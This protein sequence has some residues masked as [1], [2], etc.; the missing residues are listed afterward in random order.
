MRTKKPH[1][2]KAAFGN[3]LR[4]LRESRH[5]TVVDLAEQSKVSRQTL[6]HFEAGARGPNLLTLHALAE[7]LGVGPG[8][9]FDKS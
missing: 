7:A 1:P 5:M 4:A 3:R 8:E 2:L 6:A 9:F